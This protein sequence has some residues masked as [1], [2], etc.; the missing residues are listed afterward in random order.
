MSNKEETKIDETKIKV[1]LLRAINN[2]GKLKKGTL[3]R[4]LA[5]AIAEIEEINFETANE[6]V[7]SF[8]STLIDKGYL[9]V[10]NRE[11]TYT[12]LV[13]N[14]GIG[15]TGALVAKDVFQMTAAYNRIQ[16]S[17]EAQKRLNLAIQR[18]KAR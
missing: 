7:G 16:I 3:R 14:S 9:L 6:Q 11:G 18:A 4:E 1:E 17:R 5:S 8:L 13:G 10:N 15:G 12:S 2:A